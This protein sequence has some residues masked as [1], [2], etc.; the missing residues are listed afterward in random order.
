MDIKDINTLAKAIEEIAPFCVGWALSDR[1]DD[2]KRM[3]EARRRQFMYKEFEIPKRSGGTRRITAPTGRLKDVQKCISVILAPYYQVPDCVHGF[4]EGKSVVSNASM[5]TVKNYVLNIDLKDFFPTITYTRVVKSLKGL[6]F[7]DEVSDIIARLCT[8][9]MWDEQSQ[10]LRN[11]LPQG[12]PASPLLSNIVC[13]TLDRRLTDLARRHR[14]TY[15]RYADDMTFSSDHS[16]YAKDSSF[17]QELEDIVRSCGFKI[18]EKKTRLQKNGSRQEVTGLIVCEKVNTYRQFT[19]NL[20]AAVFH[21]E[22]NGCTPYDFNNIM[23][24]ISYLAMVK[25]PDNPNVKRFRA[26]MSKVEV[27]K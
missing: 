14:V 11:A 15:T 4:T 10:M 23:G 26:M 2:L 18:N 20:R 12:S 21:A 3:A 17:L 19:N 24:R 1:A 13:S 25:G 22:T 6:G 27:R 5:H 16:V 8:I 7:N 9:P